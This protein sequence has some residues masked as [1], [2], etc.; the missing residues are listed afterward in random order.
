MSTL[1]DVAD[2]AGVSIKTASRVVNEEAGVAPATLARVK[3]AVRRLSYVPNVSARRLVRRRAH[4]L[5]LVYQNQ[6]WNWINDFQRGAIG[7][8]GRLGYEILMHPFDV[9]TAG[10]ED[11]LLR[12][13]DQG[14]VDGLILTP[15][16]GDARALIRA[17]E[18]RGTPYTCIAPA[19][20]KGKMP[21]VS[22]SDHDGSREMGRYL[23]D[24]GH[25]RLAFVAGGPEQ[26]SSHDREA[27]FRDALEEQGIDWSSVLFLQGD[28]SFA[29]GVACGNAVLDCV[30]R[31]TAVF[32]S[33]DDMAAGILAAC[34]ERCISIPEELSVAGFDD[35]E[36]ARQVWPPLTTIH[37][38]TDEI[39]ALATRLL[40]DCLDEHAPSDRHRTLPTELVVRD[41]TGPACS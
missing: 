29:S 19:N 32:A 38:P 22:A 25:R 33:N 12:S 13:I 10:E 2:R 17:L 7:E 36:L 6:S 35:V 15:P 8:A 18:R 11:A 21:T 39:A 27:G 26:A 41:S 37:Q 28:F 4:V 40:I 24:N 5:G 30:P 31:P 23:V 1:R 16:C 20:R 9:D 34:H 3:K 14:S